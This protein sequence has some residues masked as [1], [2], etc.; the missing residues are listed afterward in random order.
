MHC[1]SIQMP[2]L[3]PFLLRSAASLVGAGLVSTL[4]SVVL[5]IAKKVG[6]SVPAVMIRWGI[7][8]D[9]IV[10]P[11]ERRSACQSARLFLFSLEHSVLAKCSRCRRGVNLPLLPRAEL[12]ALAS[13][14]HIIATMKLEEAVLCP[15]LRL[16]VCSLCLAERWW[17]A[18]VWVQRRRARS[19]WRTTST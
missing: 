15:S 1:D 10:I 16:G 7:Q 14:I 18:G 5:Q 2:P 11:S 9:C 4:V 3:P 6:K 8:R 17:G 13:N 19:M 12:F